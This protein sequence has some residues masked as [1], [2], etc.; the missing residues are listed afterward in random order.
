MVEEVHVSYP[1]ITRE[2]GGYNIYPPLLL[3]RALTN[4]FTLTYTFIKTLN[5][6]KKKSNYKW[7]VNPFAS[8]LR[9]KYGISLPC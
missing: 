9:V 4:T 6:I 1:C 3:S 5:F 8:I 2:Y 7:W